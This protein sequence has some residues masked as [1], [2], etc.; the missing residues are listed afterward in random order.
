MLE[1]S[2]HVVFGK[3]VTEFIVI[4]FFPLIIE[5]REIHHYITFSPIQFGGFAGLIEITVIVT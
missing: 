1:T 5:L 2:V 3:T 4:H